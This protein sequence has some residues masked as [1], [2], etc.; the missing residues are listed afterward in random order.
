[1]I[2]LMVYTGEPLNL[3]ALDLLFRSEEG[4]SLLPIAS[5]VSSLLSRV[6][7]E[8]PDVILIS[9]E[10]SVDW[11]LLDRLRREHPDSRLVLWIHEA[12][13]EIAFQ[14][15]E[16]GIQGI[17][18]KNLPP[19]LIVKCVR[20]IYDGEMWFEKA[21][22]QTFLSGRPIKVSRRE[23]ELITLVSQGLKNKEIATAM[24]IS[25]GTVKVY[26]SRLFGK[27]GARDRFELALIGLR[28]S[29]NWIEQ[30]SNSI[31]ALTYRMPTPREPLAAVPK[32][33][34]PH[35]ARV[36]FARTAH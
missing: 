23:G 35:S 18:R 1:M 8:K 11:A 22:T 5:D 16:S 36:L 24:D 28:N 20:K 7:S 21:L 19:E 6:P 30:S 13:P 3:I 9:V 25:E 32:K 14:A 12:T 10:A 17:L 2:V 4:I 26:M 15:I 27:F 34:E 31:H 29:N 33:A